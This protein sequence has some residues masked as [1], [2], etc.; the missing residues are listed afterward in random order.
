MRRSCATR[1]SG[2]GLGWAEEENFQVLQSRRDLGY[3]SAGSVAKNATR[4]GHPRETI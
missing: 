3:P 1:I 2:G 4:V